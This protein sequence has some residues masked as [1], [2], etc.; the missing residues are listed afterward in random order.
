MTTKFQ[1][2]QSYSQRSIC[3]SDC[4]FRF[5][6]LSRTAKTITTQVNGK[7]VRRRLSIYDGVEQFAPF[8]RY[9]MAPIVGADKL[10][11]FWYRD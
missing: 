7:T 4:I 9:S 6:I 2:G 10:D 1:I 11:R 3:D 5:E 8:G